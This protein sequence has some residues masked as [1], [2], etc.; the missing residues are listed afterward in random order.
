M[1]NNVQFWLAELDQHGNPTL[2]DGA[3]SGR[4]GVE[5][6]AYLHIRLGLTSGKR[7][8]VAQVILSD[9]TPNGKG[10]N[11]EAINIL[12]SIR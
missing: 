4:E 1:S 5:Q 2:I 12:N 3:H 8:A 7:M 11:E 10:V 9:V 6:A